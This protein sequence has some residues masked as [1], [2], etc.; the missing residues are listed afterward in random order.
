MSIQF[1]TEGWRAVISEEFTADNVRRVAQAVAEHYLQQAISAPLTMAVG[2][3]NRFLSDYFAR[4]ICEVLAANGIRAQ[5]S[6]RYVP[7]CAVSRH[8]LDRKLAAGIMVTASH[9]PGIYNGIKVKES[10][11]GSAMPQTVESIEGR[12]QNIQV[13]R[14][15]FD[16]AK[17]SGLISQADMLGGFLK[18]L[19]RF[20][21]LKAIRRARMKVI[22]DS[23]HG[24][25]ANII[26]R[27]VSGSTCRVHT[28]HPQPDPLFGGHAPEPIASHLKELIAA[29]KKTKSDVGI[30][31]DG[32]ADRLGIIGPGGRWLN[33]GQVMCLLLMHLVRARS[34]T[35]MV[36]KTVSNTMMINR[37]AQDLGL[38]LVET[39][40][41]FKY[42]VKLF[43]TDDVLIG[44]EESGGIGV[45]GYM[46][47][48]DGILNGLLLLE[49]LAE[50]GKSL[51][52]A[53]A[54]LERKYGRWHYGRRDLHLKM[55][56]IDGLFEH[57][58]ASAPG[59]MAGIPVDSV[60]RLDGVKLIGRDESWLLFRRSG[61]EPIVRVY[62]ETPKQSNL[63]RLLDFG[64]SLVQ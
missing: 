64:V 7:T 28:L 50:Q 44:G 12:L 2:F 62:A 11:G 59:D 57:L 15:A 4:A 25:G 42:I 1:G 26:E 23:M 34:A 3:D 53:M 39:P 22:V 48:R 33:P 13:K 19:K 61:T 29:V 35:G 8:V 60:N 37:V 16:D 32:D 36:V 52:A 55:D 54:G 18:G 58:R 38:R 31:N 56:Q 45:K 41:G 49:A 47:E 24:T 43:Q 10:Y 17:R 30:A 27:L 20:I 40:V 14:M 6:P 5:L 46:P 63:S 9:N 51:S 21:D